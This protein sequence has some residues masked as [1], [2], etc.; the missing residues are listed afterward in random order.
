M[1]LVGS[2]KKSPEAYKIEFDESMGLKASI[3]KFKN[4]VLPAA[5]AQGLYN[6][7][8]DLYVKN[9]PSLLSKNKNPLIPFKIHQIWLGPASPPAEF[10]T[11][12]KSI[13]ALHPGWE[14]KLWRDKDIESLNLYNKSLYKAS[15]NYGERSD[16]AR[17]EILYQFGGV[18]L[19]VDF[20]CIKSLSDFHHVYDFY[21]SIVPLDC[22]SSLANGVIGSMPRHPILR[23]CITS[24]S[25]NWHQK[26]ILLRAGPQHFEKAFWKAAQAYNGKIIAFPASF[27]FPITNTQATTIKTTEAIRPFIKPE[28]VAIHHWTGTWTHQSAKI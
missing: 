27:F 6:F 21:T 18:Y 26:T 14:Y 9:H 17:Y 28:T 3:I 22:C 20:Q 16:I 8:K 23:E 19:D 12:Q 7:L 1:S 10:K 15:K 5:Q 11:W 2:A 24:L 4:K 13:V 25:S